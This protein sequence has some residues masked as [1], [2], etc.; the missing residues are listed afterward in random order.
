MNGRSHKLGLGVVSSLF[1]EAQMQE[2]CM[3]MHRLISGDIF[4]EFLYCLGSGQ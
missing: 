2:V 3:S 4:S 1:L